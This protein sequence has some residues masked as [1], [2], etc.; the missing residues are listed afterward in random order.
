MK[1]FLIIALAATVMA[2]PMASAQDWHRNDRHHSEKYPKGWGPHRG[3][4]RK[5]YY[6]G[7]QGYRDHRPGYRRGHDGLWYPAAAF[8]LG[9]IIGGALAN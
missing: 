4:D 8:A 5:G 7:Y 3:P 9:A 1:K 2:A 6:H